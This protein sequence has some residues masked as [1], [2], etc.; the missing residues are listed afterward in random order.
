MIESKAS[1]KDIIPYWPPK[2]VPK[3]H[4]VQVITRAP[5][6]FVDASKPIKPISHHVNAEN[7]F[8]PV[9]PNT[10]NYQGLM[11]LTRNTLKS[12]TPY[13]DVLAQSKQPKRKQPWTSDIRN[14]KLTKE[15][16]NFIDSYFSNK[17]ELTRLEIE[18]NKQHQLIR[19]KEFLRA[20][21]EQIVL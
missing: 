7:K 18:R 3:G 19:Q 8:G 17:I 14:R 2:L 1:N 13:L 6:I 16:E 12:E 20:Q 9:F 15:P 10:P 21:P 5:E 4:P 11:T